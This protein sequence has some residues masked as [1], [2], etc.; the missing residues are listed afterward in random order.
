VARSTGFQV[1]VK[2][3]VAPSHEV[4]HLAYLYTK[5][6]QTVVNWLVGTKT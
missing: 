2:M 3:K 4:I 1:T 5:A 6:K